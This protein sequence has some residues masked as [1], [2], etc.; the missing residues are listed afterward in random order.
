MSIM[1][2]HQAG[3]S[4][5]YDWNV[6]DNRRRC[7]PVSSKRDQP[8]AVVHLLGAVGEV[9]PTEDREP[10]FRTPSVPRPD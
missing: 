7:S 6:V 2:A 8:S 5:T 3:L 4:L 9:D 1:R 10:K